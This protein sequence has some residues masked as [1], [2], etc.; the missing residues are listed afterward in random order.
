[1]RIKAGKIVQI[2]S[3]AWF[4]SKNRFVSELKNNDPII[5]PTAVVIMIKTSMA[6][7]W[8]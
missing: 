4:S 8:N 2:I 6:W 7:S 3:T 5:Y 1:M